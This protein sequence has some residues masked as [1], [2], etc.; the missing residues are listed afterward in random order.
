MLGLMTNQFS[1]IESRN[2]VDAR[3]FTFCNRH[4]SRDW[5]IWVW[6]MESSSIALL[7]LANQLKQPARFVGLGSET[8]WPPIPLENGRNPLPLLMWI[9][10]KW[11]SE[12]KRVSERNKGCLLSEFF[13]GVGNLKPTP[14]M[15][16]RVIF[17]QAWWLVRQ[18]YRREK[19]TDF[20]DIEPEP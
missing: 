17:C 5:Y 15:S 20:R 1:L 14:M 7:P 9:L 18:E 6:K 4:S 12:R 8:K 10:W 2:M 19:K 3:S 13:Q 16:L 11:G